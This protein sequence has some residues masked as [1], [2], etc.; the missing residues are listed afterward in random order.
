MEALQA[1]EEKQDLSCVVDVS[2]LR[3]TSSS[4]VCTPLACLFSSAFV[5]VLLE[6]LSR[7]CGCA[8]M[9]GIAGAR[10]F[11]HTSTSWFWT[12]VVTVQ[13][14]SLFCLLLRRPAPCS[15]SRPTCRVKHS[16]GSDNNMLRIRKVVTRLI[17]VQPILHRWPC[18]WG[19]HEPHQNPE[20][21]NML[22]F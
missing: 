1:L 8:G 3:S 22:C 9:R 11:V 12:R 2:R 13:V 14:F 18:E 20:S 6:F 15:C 5:S 7:I 21:E 10:D 16:R 4:S 17:A 19:L